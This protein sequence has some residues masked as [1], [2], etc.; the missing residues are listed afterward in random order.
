MKALTLAVMTGVCSLMVSCDKPTEVTTEKTRELTT[1]DK[2]P[3]SLNPT[4]D[5]QFN[6]NKGAA[7]KSDG[8]HSHG[9]GQQAFGEFSY[10]AEASWVAKAPSQFRNVNFALPKGGELYV[11]IVGGGVLPNLNRWFGQFGNS[12]ISPEELAQQERIT[13][14]GEKG[15]YA[16]ATGDYNPGMGRPAKGNMTLLGALAQVNGQL[17]TVKL[18]A[19]PEEA[20]EQK[21]AFKTFCES[22]ES[23]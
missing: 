17:V 22:L 9:G 11:S 19:T 15:Y 10:T 4:S 2:R 14:L 20:E 1:L 7:P 21:A 3:V 12:A 16:E 18:I 6:P 8:G 5:D 23:K 13:L